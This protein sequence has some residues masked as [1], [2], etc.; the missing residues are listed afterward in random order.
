MTLQASAKKGMR[1]RKVVSVILLCLMVIQIGFAYVV[2]SELNQKSTEPTAVPEEPKV[3]VIC[4]IS[5]IQ[6]RS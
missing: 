5:F 6:S 1:R 3:N 2:V 4:G